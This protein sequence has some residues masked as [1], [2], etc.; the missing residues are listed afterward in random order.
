M[1]KEEEIDV[2][3]FFKEMQK[4]SMCQENKFLE[5]KSDINTLIT[6]A[7]KIK[8]DPEEY[9][10]LYKKRNENYNEFKLAMD[11]ND[12]L[13]YSLEKGNSAWNDFKINTRNTVLFEDEKKEKKCKKA[14]WLSGKAL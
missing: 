1:E 8:L 6:K 14:K 9:I 11:K 13:I 4:F 3:N 7:N 2:I 5:D 10:K 12:R